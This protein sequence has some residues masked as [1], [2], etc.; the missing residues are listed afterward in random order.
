MIYKTIKA[1]GVL[2][3]NVSHPIG[4]KNAGKFKLCIKKN[5]SLAAKKGKF[6]IGWYIKLV[7]MR[8]YSRECLLKT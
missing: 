3:K 5:L 4:F 8:I 2:Q 7:N 1:G 6:M